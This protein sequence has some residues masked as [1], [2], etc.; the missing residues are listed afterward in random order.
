MIEQARYIPYQLP[1]NYPLPLKGTQ[2]SDREGFIVELYSDGC[3]GY[4]DI[5]PL[6]SFSRETLDDARQYLQELCN[7][8][9]AL[10]DFE[11]SQYPPSVAFGIESALWSLKQTRWRKKPQT[12]PLFLGSL[13]QILPRL[14]PWQ[15][16]W[17]NEVKI[18]VGVNSPQQEIERIKRVLDALPESVNL[19]LDANQRWNMEQAI[20]VGKALPTDRIAYI[21]EPVANPDDLPEFY[22]NTGVAYALDE[23]VQL[24]GYKFQSLSG[25]AALVLKPTL[26]GGISHC[27]SLVA[28]A[29]AQGVRTIFSSSFES[30]VGIHIIEQLSTWLTPDEWPGLDT[31]TAFKYPLVNDY[32]RPGK[33]LTCFP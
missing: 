22:Q 2:L 14:Q 20:M 6:P 30:S 16:V 32:P 15:S 31:V 12:S 9:Q 24:P 29:R 33:E 18:K 17:P 8:P 11:A 3:Y 25:L 19:R 4:G 10:L 27:R 23:T 13:E 5:T 21:E 28:E 26:V 7:N 1:L